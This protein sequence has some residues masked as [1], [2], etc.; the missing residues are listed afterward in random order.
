MGLSQHIPHK[1]TTVSNYTLDSVIISSTRVTNSSPF[2]HTTL[3][4][5][6][7]KKEAS[8][9]SLPM[10]IGYQPSVVATTEGGLGLGYTKFSVRGSSSSRTNITL[11]GISVGDGESQEFFWVNLPSLSSSL[12]SVQLQRGVGTSVNGPGAFGATLNMRTLASAVQ[13]Y[14]NAEFSLGSYSTY[15][16]SIA[17]GTGRIS[18]KDSYFS[19]D[20]RYS[21]SNTHGYIRNAKASLNSIFLQG[22]W[23]NKANLLKLIYIYGDQSTGITWDGVPI[24]IYY[25]NRKYN[26]AGE[27]Y[28]DDG[29]LHYYDNETDNYAQHHTQL[30]YVRSFTPYLTLNSTLHFTKG[31]GYY[32]NYKY[33]QKF[34]KYGL[35]DQTIDGQVYKKSDFI[36]RQLMDNNYLAGA[37]SLNYLKENMSLIAGGNYSYYDG[38]HFGRLNWS[39]YNQNI[40]EK[41]NWYDNNGKKEDLSLFTKGQ[42]RLY[43]GLSIYADIQYRY[44]DYRLRGIDKDFVNL[45]KNLSYSFF[46]PKGGVIYDINDKNRVYF[47]VATAHREPSRS[48]I[49]ES[50]KALRENEIKKERLLDYELGYTFSKNNFSANVN[51]YAMEYKNQLVATGRLTET[52]YVIQENIPNSYRRGIELSFT[53]K[54]VSW[55]QFGGNMTLSKNKLKDY[56]LFVDTYD[57]SVDWNPV[58]QTKVF[59][60]SSHLTLSPEFIGSAFVNFF[61]CN[62]LEISFNAKQIGKQ[63]MDNSSL[64]IAKVP[65]YFVLNANISKRF[66]INSS[67][68]LSLNLAIDNLL[69]NKYYSYGWIYRAVFADGSPDYVEKAVYSQA[70]IN[71]LFKVAIE[72]R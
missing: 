35:S 47:S 53:Y 64:E 28:D 40:P 69:N 65:S 33:N 44:I 60:K 17:S 50:I 9:H 62:N 19:F 39:K 49:K 43:K 8:S 71:M 59:L 54:P 58:E 12:Q 70:P 3:Y 11:N 66:A 34:S 41:Y 48:D 27:Y 13:P 57:N 24:N 21:Y 68:T 52:G 46:N 14:L 55:I 2:A 56:T 61:P 37:I 16:A 67:T 15:I 51:L 30:H 63:Y 42:F 4:K 38:D 18:L 7:L 45:D 1:D 10:I 23:E 72:F 22:I 25:T 36:I 31:D 20:A 5:D 6:Y 29:I 26:S 32:E